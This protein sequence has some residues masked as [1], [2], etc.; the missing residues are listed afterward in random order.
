MDFDMKILVVDDFRT[1]RMILRK[2]LMQIGFT[3]ITEADDGNTAYR[4]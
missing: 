2:I 1:L 3:N 4:N